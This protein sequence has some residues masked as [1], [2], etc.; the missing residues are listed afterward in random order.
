MITLATLSLRLDRIPKFNYF[1]SD[2][3]QHI[4]VSATERDVGPGS[5]GTHL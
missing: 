2:F 4:L 1:Y 5:G 3:S